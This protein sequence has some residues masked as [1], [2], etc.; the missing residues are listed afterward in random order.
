[1]VHVR[2]QFVQRQ[3][4]PHAMDEHGASGMLR[5]PS[6]WQTEQLAGHPGHAQALPQGSVSQQGGSMSAPQ[7]DAHT[8]HRSSARSVR[9]AFI[10]HTTFAC[11]RDYCKWTLATT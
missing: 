11:F 5:S 4:V 2:G 3:A 8:D 7:P 1:M 9:Q 10:L 6:P